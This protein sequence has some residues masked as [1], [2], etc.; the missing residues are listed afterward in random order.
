MVGI[1]K[2]F[3]PREP[4][5][6]ISFAHEQQHRYWARCLAIMKYMQADIEVNYQNVPVYFKPKAYSLAPVCSFQLRHLFIDQKGLTEL[7]RFHRARVNPNFSDLDFH[8]AFRFPGPYANSVV[9][10][11]TDG[12]QASIHVKRPITTA[13]TYSNEI[14]ITP[15]TIILGLDPNKGGGYIAG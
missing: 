9:L 5:W 13:I 15:E 14:Q 7:C 2:G 4:N 10:F 6:L 8:Q 11:T 3:F 1:W 12:V